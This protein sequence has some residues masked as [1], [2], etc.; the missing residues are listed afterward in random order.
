MGLVH[1]KDHRTCGLYTKYTICMLPMLLHDVCAIC[2]ISSYELGTIL[3]LIVT[4][5]MKLYFFKILVGYL[6][7]WHHW[8]VFVSSHFCGYC[9]SVALQLMMLQLNRGCSL[10]LLQIWPAS[11]ILQT[12]IFNLDYGLQLVPTFICRD[13]QIFTTAKPLL[14]NVLYKMQLI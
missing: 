4:V 1:R 12:R 10:S 3:C 9:F 2:T 11:A 6:F 8:F 7:F 5:N 14:N 13:C